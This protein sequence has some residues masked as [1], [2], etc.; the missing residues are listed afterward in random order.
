MPNPGGGG[1]CCCGIAFTLIS[2]SAVLDEG[3]ARCI[4]AALLP[5][6]NLG[7]WFSWYTCREE[8]ED[9]ILIASIFREVVLSASKG[10]GVVSVPG[11]LRLVVGLPDR[12]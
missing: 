3:A 5:L 11:L 10:T 6:T 4:V 12:R 7:S 2:P 1:G 8:E 9:A